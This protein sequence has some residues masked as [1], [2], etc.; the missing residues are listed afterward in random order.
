M[1]TTT[2]SERGASAPVVLQPKTKR[3]PAKTRWAMRSL[4]VRYATRATSARAS[5]QSIMSQTGHRSVQMVR[6]YI[7]MGVCSGRI[8]RGNSA[9]SRP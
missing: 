8:A 5:E 2:E 4:W 1:N 3:A 6:R 9:C 7:K